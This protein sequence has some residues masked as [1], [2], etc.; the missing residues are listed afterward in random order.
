MQQN[1]CADGHEEYT[2]ILTDA[3]GIPCGKVCDRCVDYRKSKYR[4]EI[5][6]DASYHA[7]EPIE[8]AY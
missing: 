7:D 3:R 8:E 6:E 4:P 2:Y 1:P 5:F